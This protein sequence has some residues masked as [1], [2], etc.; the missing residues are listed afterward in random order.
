MIKKNLNFKKKIL[1]D[2]I[3]GSEV[4]KLKHGIIKKIPKNFTLLKY[5]QK[6][7]TFKDIE[8]YWGTRIND[9]ILKKSKNIKWIHFGSVGTDKVSYEIIKKRGI[10]V[11]NSAKIN[12]NSVANLIMQLLLDTEKKIMITKKSYKNFNRNIYEKKFKFAKDLNK[13]KV[14]I[15]GYGNITKNLI[16]KMKP[17]KIDF[18]IFS[19]RKINSKNIINLKKMRQNL[20]YYDTIINLLK[21][22]KKN[23]NFIDHNFLRNLKKNINLF[24]IGRLGTNNLID[25]L[26]FSKKDKSSSI[27]IDGILD[28]K[29]N[30]INKKLLN[31]N[32]V[33]TLP[34]IGGYFKDYWSLQEKLFIKNLERY[35]FSKKLIN[36]VKVV[37]EN[38]L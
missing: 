19:R 2:F 21:Y 5:S 25:I 14:L 37:K 15:L 33:F 11:T 20:K 7:K 35:Q 26:N 28:K 18:E 23:K 29:T 36:E 16:K 24:L 30:F 32:N 22:N 9:Q 10:L 6:L 17:F 34:H 3:Y 27:Y 1:T 31:K 8:I 13:Q 4:Y 38:F 12:S